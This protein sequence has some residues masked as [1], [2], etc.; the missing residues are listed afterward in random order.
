M[1]EEP[2][3]TLRREFRRFKLS[4]RERLVADILVDFSLA[5]GRKAVRIPGFS[6]ITRITGLPPAFVER[7]FD[8]LA[9]MRIL[10]MTVHPR[11]LECELL[12]NSYQWQCTP[13]VMP[14]ELTK[15]AK[16]LSEFNELNPG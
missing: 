11:Y 7:T 15:A 6:I 8:S 13:R 9:L 14:D 5:V 2:S 3:E 10:K 4:E 16:E 1:P 12:P